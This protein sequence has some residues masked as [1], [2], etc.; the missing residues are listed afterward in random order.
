MKFVVARHCRTY[1]NARGWIQGLKD[2]P[3]DA[4]GK[5]QAAQLAED[6]REHNIATIYSSDLLR[7]KETASI[8]GA[9]VGALTLTSVSLREC[10]FGT[11]DGVSFVEFMFR[12]GWKNL[13]FAK[14]ALDADFTR[15]GGDRGVDLFARQ[16]QFL[17]DC[18]TCFDDGR[19]IMIVGHARSLRT[20]LAPLGHPTDWLRKQGSHIV[21]EY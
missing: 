20:L 6:V 21:I 15:F 9:A 12:C 2:I 14:Y 8:V 7:A 19:T 1:Y 13:P 11:L 17:D 5:S 3:L 16:K 10:D 4:I 18:K